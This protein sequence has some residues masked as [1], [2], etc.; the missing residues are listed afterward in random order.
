MVPWVVQSPVVPTVTVL[1]VVL[2][3]RVVVPVAEGLVWA[4]GGVEVQVVVGLGAPL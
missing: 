4:A 1:P 3:V 2:I